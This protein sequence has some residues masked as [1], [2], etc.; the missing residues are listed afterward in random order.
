MSILKQI[1][2]ACVYVTLMLGLFLGGWYLI[3]A[4]ITALIKPA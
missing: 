3:A 1:G 4:I 2:V